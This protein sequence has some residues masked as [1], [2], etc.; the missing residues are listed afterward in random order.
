MI[1][2]SCPT[3]NAPLTA[4][5]ELAGEKMFCHCGQ[6]LLIPSPPRPK[7]QNKTVLGLLDPPPLP[8]MLPGGKSY[9]RCTSCASF[10][11]VPTSLL[12]QTVR[13]PMCRAEFPAHAV[14][15][16]T[17]PQGIQASPERVLPQP[18]STTPPP[19]NPFDFDR[20][21]DDP[22]SPRR[23]RRRPRQEDS[24]E[25]AA[26]ERASNMEIVSF[27]LGLLA[28][29]FVCLPILGGPLGLVSAIMGGS[30]MAN[31]RSG[32]QAITGLILGILAMIGSF[33]VFMVFF[34]AE[35]RRT[36]F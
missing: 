12:G 2:F 4:G 6:R 20:V 19:P 7:P 22:P 10:G 11:L 24:E 35:L 13:C 34:E 29:H 26:G 8:P 1:N 27:V 23:R 15:K 36:R 5:D 21:A 33:L 30:A 9:V 18:P 25:R 31:Q 32:W 14:M 17:A 16:P 3:C 28:I